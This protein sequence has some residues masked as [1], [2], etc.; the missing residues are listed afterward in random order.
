MVFFYLFLLIISLYS[1]LDF[2][3]AFFL[4]FIYYSSSSSSSPIPVLIQFRNRFISLWNPIEEDINGNQRS[5]NLLQRRLR[6]EVRFLTPSLVPTT[7]DAGFERFQRLLF[8]LSVKAFPLS[9][10]LKHRYASG[11]FRA[12]RRRRRR[13]RRKWEAFRR[14][15]LGFDSR[16][17]GFSDHE[18]R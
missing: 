12:R 1:L 14:K 13:W 3:A 7:S 9:N 16:R 8:F 4:S 10:C 5:R 2:S 17:L 11:E 6:S 15:T 18:V